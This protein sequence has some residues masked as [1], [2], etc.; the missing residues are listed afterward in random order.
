MRGSPCL[1][2]ET[3]RAQV[4]LPV[5]L[6]PSVPG[7]P[8][9]AA[10]SQN[11]SGTYLHPFHKSNR[12]GAVL[13]PTTAHLFAFCNSSY[14]LQYPF[15]YDRLQMSPLWFWCQVENTMDCSLT[16]KIPKIIPEILTFLCWHTLRH[17]GSE[18]LKNLTWDLHTHLC[19]S[20]FSLGLDRGEAPALPSWLCHCPW[21]LAPRPWHSHWPLLLPVLR[22]GVMLPGLSNNCCSLH[23]HGLFQNSPWGWM[24]FLLPQTSQNFSLSV[25]VLKLLPGE[26]RVFMRKF[27]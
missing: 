9:S 16:F 3:H 13:C 24:W 15:S 20:A 17:L 2:W 19:P 6:M 14:Y 22:L 1:P 25:P 27:D 10:A 23:S 18:A 11:Q 21:L 12:D 5:V 4:P 26:F 8:A 7:S